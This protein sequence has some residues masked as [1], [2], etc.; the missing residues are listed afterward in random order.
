MQVFSF[1]RILRSP[2][3]VQQLAISEDFLRV[4]SQFPQQVIFRGRQFH[5]LPA[6]SDLSLHEIN[7]HV[8]AH[9]IRLGAAVSLT[10]VRRSTALIRA[11]SSPLPNGLVI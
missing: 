3:P 1:L 8:P 5:N 11:T 10:R 6:H 2:D 9:E 7:F 4:Q